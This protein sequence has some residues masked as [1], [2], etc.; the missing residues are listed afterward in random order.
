MAEKPEMSRAD[1]PQDLPYMD[2]NLDLESRIDDLL[3]RLTFEEKLL[4]CSPARFNRIVAIPRLHIPS[5][6][7]TDGP[8]GL[9]RWALKGKTCII[10]RPRFSRHP[11]GIPL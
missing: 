7:E 8:H 3:N 9:P 5:Y 2:M 1:N 11:R 6:M 4:L 10:F